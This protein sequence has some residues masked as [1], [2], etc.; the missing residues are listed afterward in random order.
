ML[1]QFSKFPAVLW[2]LFAVGLV[3]FFEYRGGQGFYFSVGLLV[4]L[5][6]VL[7]AIQ[8]FRMRKSP[9]GG[10]SETQHIFSDSGIATV[11]GWDQ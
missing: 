8:T 7:P 9:G 5:V 1:R 6:G 3:A 2:L 4:F 10:N 11:M